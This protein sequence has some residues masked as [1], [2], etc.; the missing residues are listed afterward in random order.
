MLLKISC[1]GHGNVELRT[2]EAWT[3][4]QWADTRLHGD[5]WN[6]RRAWTRWPWKVPS[7]PNPFDSVTFW[8]LFTASLQPPVSTQCRCSCRHLFAAWLDFVMTMES[9]YTPKPW[10]RQW[11]AGVFYSGIN[12]QL[13]LLN[14]NIQH[15]KFFSFNG[16]SIVCVGRGAFTTSGLT[17]QSEYQ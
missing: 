5:I 15:K 3:Q 16:Q 10:W 6:I 13:H 12:G 9:S 7:H 2:K 4:L 1:L 8:H 17:H 14:F 11:A